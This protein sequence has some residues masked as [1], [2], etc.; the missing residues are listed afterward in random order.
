[1]VE[2]IFFFENEQNKRPHVRFECVRITFNQESLT[3]ANPF[4]FVRVRLFVLCGHLLG[5]G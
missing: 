5:K 4:V 2:S 3:F 1:M